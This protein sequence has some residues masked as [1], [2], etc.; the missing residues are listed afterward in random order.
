MRLVLLV[1][2]ALVF[3]DA[4]PDALPDASE[5]VQQAR[6]EWLPGGDGNQYL[7]DQWAG[8][9]C[10]ETATARIDS[11]GRETPKAM[12]KPKPEPSPD[13]PIPSPKIDAGLSLVVVTSKACLPCQKMRPILDR[14]GGKWSIRYVDFEDPKVKQ[15]LEVYQIASVP[16]Y[17]TYRGHEALEVA[18]GLMTLEEALG[19]L[20]RVEQKLPPDADGRFKKCTAQDSLKPID[21]E[22]LQMRLTPGS[23][24]MLG[25]MAHGGG[26][27]T[28]LAN[29]T[30]ET[31]KPKGHWE[32]QPG[33]CPTC[34][35][36]RVWVADPD[37]TGT[38]PWDSGSYGG[39]R[40]GR[41]WGSNQ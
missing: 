2:F 14:I 25:C 26:W 4:M 34:P 28:E 8:W 41:R 6:G 38:V 23:C 29:E 1:L 15:W 22:Y 9:W 16:Y 31:K 19:W 39:G 33:L 7:R 10:Y 5:P 18:E 13:I 20:G 30:P 3:P 27:I 17:I 11:V 24:G 36:T 32:M 21:R 37:P 40:F 35:S 12:G